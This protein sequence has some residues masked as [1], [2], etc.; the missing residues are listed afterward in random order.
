[1]I[2]ATADRRERGTAAHGCANDSDGVEDQKDV[3]NDRI[4]GALEVGSGV[5][6][7]RVVATADMYARHTPAYVHPPPADAQAILAP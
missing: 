1:M 3:V 7:R 5:P 4:P 6:I 2:V